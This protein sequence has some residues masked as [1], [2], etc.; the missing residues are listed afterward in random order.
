MGKLA[1]LKIN[2]V[3]KFD[4][5]E[6]KIMGKENSSRIKDDDFP[7]F[8]VKIRLATSQMR[9]LSGVFGV[10]LSKD[11]EVIECVNIEKLSYLEKLDSKSVNLVQNINNSILEPEIKKKTETPEE[12]LQRKLQ[13]ARQMK[14]GTVQ[15]Q[16]VQEEKTSEVNFTSR[17][18]RQT[19][20]ANNTHREKLATNYDLPL[21]MTNH[22]KRAPKD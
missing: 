20:P 4:G 7:N 14:P 16:K 17:R 18:K 2:L 19:S 5:K 12:M 10:K 6:F 11:S 22:G 21:P 3:K 15:P 9:V 1:S 8:V 13:A